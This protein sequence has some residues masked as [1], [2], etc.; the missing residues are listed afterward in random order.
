[1]ARLL[2]CTALYFVRQVF[3]NPQSSSG[4]PSPLDPETVQLPAFSILSAMFTG[5]CG[6]PEEL[7]LALARRSGLFNFFIGKVARPSRSSN[8]DILVSNISIQPR[9]CVSVT[10]KSSSPYPAPQF[11][12]SVA[13]IIFL[14]MALYKGCVDMFSS[15]KSCTICCMP[16]M[17]TTSDVE[18]GHG[19]FHYIWYDRLRATPLFPPLIL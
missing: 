19:R 9:W 17:M 15:F 8:R 6:P 7:S 2:F 1:M 4:L 14:H 12:F 13:R 11:T 18:D 5:A 3:G 16:P 10:V